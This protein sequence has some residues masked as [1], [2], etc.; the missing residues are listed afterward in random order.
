MIYINAAEND[1]Y[2]EKH[3]SHTEFPP[4]TDTSEA[5]ICK[6]IY[7]GCDRFNYHVAW[8]YLSFAETASSPEY[9][10]AEYREHIK[11]FQ[12][13]PTAEAVRGLSDY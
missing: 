6:R 12:A 3:K 9:Q 11:P 2:R 8:G 5:E 1:Q 10:P 4:L 7:N 13:V